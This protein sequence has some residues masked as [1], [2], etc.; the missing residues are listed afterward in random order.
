MG[1]LPHNTMTLTPNGN[2]KENSKNQKVFKILL[3]NFSKV[4]DFVILQ[5][6]YIHSTTDLL[7]AY[8]QK[9]RNYN[10]I[11]L[12]KLAKIGDGRIMGL[13]MGNPAS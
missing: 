1:K 2:Q 12:V 8:P 13:T 9:R 4:I 6:L 10:R 5:L 7:L 3:I 11:A